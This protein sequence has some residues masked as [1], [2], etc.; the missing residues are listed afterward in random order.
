MFLTW[1]RCA[2]TFLF[3]FIFDLHPA[4]TLTTPYS[5]VNMIQRGIEG[6][7]FISSEKKNRN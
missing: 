1:L 2:V 7:F 5:G 4:K 3:A 6:L